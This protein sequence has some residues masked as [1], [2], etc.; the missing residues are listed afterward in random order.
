[1]STMKLT[2]LGLDNWYKSE[3]AGDIFDGL[4]LPT[5]IDKATL[6]NNIL[7]QSGEFEVLYADPSFM[8]EAIRLSKSGTKRY[9]LSITLWTT[10]TATKNT[11]TMAPQAKQ[12]LVTVQLATAQR[13]LLHLRA[14]FTTT[15]TLH[16]TKIIQRLWKVATSKVI[17]TIRTK[18]TP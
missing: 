18:T 16:R 4:T 11:R 2:M 9:K 12:T 8:F 6:T 7:L 13:P 17:L 10:S 14:K 15:T 1:M 5:G 3:N